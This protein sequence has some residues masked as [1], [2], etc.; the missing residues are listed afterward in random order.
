MIYLIYLNLANL[1]NLP[2][3]PGNSWLA[4]S[5]SIYLIIY[6]FDHLFIHLFVVNIYVFSN[7]HVHLQLRHEFHH[8]PCR[9]DSSTEYQK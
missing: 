9:F 2:K 3:N 6:S 1:E 8:Y 5:L 7:V 4:R